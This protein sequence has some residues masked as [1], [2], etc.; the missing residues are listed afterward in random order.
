MVLLVVF[1][2]THSSSV[3]PELKFLSS[4]LF[5]VGAF[6]VNISFLLF[7]RVRRQDLILHVVQVGLRLFV[8]ELDFELL[9]LPLVLK[10]QNYRHMPLHPVYVGD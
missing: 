9:I 2:S 10:C 5:L 4:S 8:A 7:R 3:L 6:E 1:C